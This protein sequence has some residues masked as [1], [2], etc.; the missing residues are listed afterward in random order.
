MAFSTKQ[1]NDLLID[2]DLAPPNVTVDTPLVTSSNPFVEVGVSLHSNAP[3]RPVIIVS[4]PNS[5]PGELGETL[6]ESSTDVQD[7]QAFVQSS[8]DALKANSQAIE[9]LA[10]KLE[11]SE[12]EPGVSHHHHF[13]HHH[14]HH[15]HQE[16]HSQK[17]HGQ[18]H[19][20]IKRPGYETLNEGQIAM[21][22]FFDLSHIFASYRHQKKPKHDKKKK[23]TDG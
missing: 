3:S 5:T 8:A 2:F 13:E 11:S 16:H 4:A 23:S 7:Y 20:V 10:S 19:V 1:K 18:P 22:G 21:D 9:S 15:H 12:I 17:H 6:F 14:H